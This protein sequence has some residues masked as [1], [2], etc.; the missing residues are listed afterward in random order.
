[1]A[2]QITNDEF[3]VD[4]SGWDVVLTDTADGSI[5]ASTVSPYNGAASCLVTIVNPGASYASLTVRQTSF[6]LTNNVVYRVRAAMK[7]DSN[8]SFV[9]RVKKNVSPFTNYG[10]STSFNLTTAW[11]IFETTFTANATV[12]DAQLAFD[13]GIGAANVSIDQV[14][15][16]PLLSGNSYVNNPIYLDTFSAD[17]DI[18]NSLFGNSNRFLQIRAIKF[19]SPTAGDY[20][21]FTDSI[22]SVI[23]ELKCSR[24]NEDVVVRF[25]KPYFSNGLK[26]LAANASV[27]AGAHILI[28]LV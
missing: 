7:A 18:A 12:T 15:F 17:I 28:Y 19:F 6:S 11:K 24:T 1:M 2:N 20:V 8:R 22:G 25:K 10:L 3:D 23:G 14:V 27:T 13:C 4:T 16:E 9:M 21:I 26:L 5:S